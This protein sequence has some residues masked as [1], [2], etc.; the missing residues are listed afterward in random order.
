VKTYYL[1]GS[2]DWKALYGL[3]GKFEGWFSAD[4]ARVPIFAKMNV[5]IGN[6]EIELKSWKRNN[7]FPPK[8]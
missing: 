4:E 7:W 1:S 2:A 5:Y 6:I 8:Y 3:G